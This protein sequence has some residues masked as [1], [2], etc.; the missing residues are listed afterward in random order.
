MLL[1]EQLARLRY[2]EVS[3]GTGSSSTMESNRPRNREKRV[4]RG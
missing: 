2:K 1:S 4:L 3:F